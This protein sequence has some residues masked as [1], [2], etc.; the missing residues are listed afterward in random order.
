MQTV[1]RLFKLFEQTLLWGN[2]LF[3]LMVLLYSTAGPKKMRFD[4]T[5]VF[6]AFMLAPLLFSFFIKKSVRNRQR[7]Q[8]EEATE[9]PVS[10]SSQTSGEP[11]DSESQTTQDIPLHTSFP[12]FKSGFT[13]KPHRSSSFHSFQVPTAMIPESLPQKKNSHRLSCSSFWCR[14]IF[15]HLVHH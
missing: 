11:L 10:D 5:I 2:S 4:V 7:E 3:W 15:W 8:Q 14:Y 9:Q 13:N 1:K 12:P 6:L